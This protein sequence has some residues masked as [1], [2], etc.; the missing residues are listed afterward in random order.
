MGWKQISREEWESNGQTAPPQVEP[1]AEE[2]PR[3]EA[4]L[5]GI[6][7]E[8]RRKA[9]AILEKQVAERPARQSMKDHMEDVAKRVREELDKPWP[10]PVREDGGKIVMD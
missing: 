10:P 6:S 2:K 3:S 8:L 7:D 9:I 4:S 1:P 5:R